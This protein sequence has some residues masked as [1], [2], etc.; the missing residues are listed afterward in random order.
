MGAESNLKNGAVNGKADSN[1]NPNAGTGKRAEGNSTGATGAGAAG[2]GTGTGT[3]GTGTAGAGKEEKKLSGV[4]VVTVEEPKEQQ[5]KKETEPKAPAPKKPKK[6]R[7]QA[8][9]KDPALPVEQV[10][11]LIVSLSSLVAARPGQAHW[12]I[13]EA[14]AH[15]VS[16]P[17]CNIL[18]KT[19]VLQ[20]FGENS[21]AVALALAAF[22]LVMPR[23]M[24]SVSI[25]KEKKKIER[26][27]QTVDVAVKEKPIKKESGRV[28][29]RDDQHAGT[30]VGTQDLLADL[31][32]L[33]GDIFG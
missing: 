30:A 16:V 12:A 13:S 29:K 32:Y 21:D 22:T 31:S 26:T 2:T 6:T 18:E 28:P 7:K 24:I 4:A 11:A 10:D 8:K 1:T 23:A 19:E 14:E 25:A 5:D 20:K 17:L 27:G 3:A 15:S 33:G 9:A